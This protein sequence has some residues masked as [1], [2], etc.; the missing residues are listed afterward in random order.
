MNYLEQVLI[1]LIN[2]RI[3]KLQLNY[4]KYIHI[5]KH[6]KQLISQNCLDWDK[7]II[8]HNIL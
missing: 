3:I 6:V 2:S 1:V 7:I 4:K 5:I 8:I